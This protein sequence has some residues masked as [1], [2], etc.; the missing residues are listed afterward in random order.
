MRSG[1]EKSQVLTREAERAGGD[2]LGENFGRLTEVS[3]R[4]WV[5]TGDQRE[6]MRLEDRDEPGLTSAQVRV[7]VRAAAL[8]YRDL[9]MCDEP[10]RP[11]LV[12]LSDGGGEVVEVGSGV[13]ALR[14]GDRVVGGFFASWDSGIAGQAGPPA[15]ARCGRGAGLHDR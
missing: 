9:L 13:T 6:P 3:V 4:S 14:P 8:N 1:P 5:L 2:V 10:Q 15:R 12:P 11:G 7:E